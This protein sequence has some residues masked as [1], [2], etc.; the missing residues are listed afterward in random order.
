[1]PGNNL[2]HHISD[3]ALWAAIHRAKETE[4]LDP[5]FRDPF[6]RRLAGER[7]EQ[8]AAGLSFSEA[9]EWSWM[10]R[11]Y[12]F[13]RFINEQVRQG[14]DMVVNLGAGLDARPY[15]MSWPESLTWVEVDLPGILNYKEKIL[16]SDQPQCRL[17]RVR[18]DLADVAGRR[19]LFESLGRR[20][21][22][23]LVVTEGVMIY[24]RSDDAGVLADDL[25]AVST[26]QYWVLDLASPGL[27][28][29]LRERTERQLSE[30][31]RMQFA[32]E[33]GPEFFGV[34]GWKAVDVQ[35]LLKAAGRLN[36]LP[37]AMQSLALLPEDPARMGQQPW[38]GACL[39]EHS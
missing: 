35:S 28:R 4:R 15:R 39:L 26:F 12:L 10:A 34:H 30:T 7:G 38:G 19:V 14:V 3:T 9:D 31:T 6:A 33:N 17:E 37:P 23:A 20:A 13:D 5:Q 16:A 2:I 1:M 21:A 29:I 22:R 27:L 11:T 18:L 8:I 32:P 25:A 24:L 36:R